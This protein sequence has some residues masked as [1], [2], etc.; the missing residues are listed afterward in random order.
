MGIHCKQ[1][2]TD[3]LMRHNAM[4]ISCEPRQRLHA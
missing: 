4:R 3:E 2:T 1:T